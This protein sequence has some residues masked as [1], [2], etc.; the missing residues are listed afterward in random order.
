[1]TRRANAGD[2][3]TNRRAFHD[4]EVLDRFEAGLALT[5]SEVKSLR[6]RQ[7]NIREGYVRI[8]GHEAWLENVHISHYEQAGIYNHDPLRSRKLLLHRREISSLIGK[9]HEKGLTLVPLRLYL[10]D[11]RVKVELGLCRGKRLY[12]KRRALAEAEAKRD[13]GRALRRELID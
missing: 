9:L 13:I 6:A 7:V 4:F 1:M 10:L 11:G 3:A 5:G 2:I 12:D 8:L